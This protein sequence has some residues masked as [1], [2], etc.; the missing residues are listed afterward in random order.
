[1]SPQVHEVTR[2]CCTKAMA[3]PHHSNT[4]HNHQP[5]RSKRERGQEGSRTHSTSYLRGQT[6]ALFQRGLRPELGPT[7]ERAFL[8]AAGNQSLWGLFP[9]LLP[10]LLVVRPVLL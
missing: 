8:G 9:L 6:T 7:K 3:Q 1:M 10:I 4:S 5:S 2:L